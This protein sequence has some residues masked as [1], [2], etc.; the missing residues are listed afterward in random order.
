MEI[1]AD[2]NVTEILRRIMYQNTFDPILVTGNKKDF[3]SCIFDTLT[4][5]NIEQSGDNSMKPYCAI[6][7]N[8]TK[9]DKCLRNLEK[10]ST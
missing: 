1:L 2:S 8:K 9:F 6:K 7:F 3:P 4:V 10:I 5:I